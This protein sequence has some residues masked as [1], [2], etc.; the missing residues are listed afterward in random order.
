MTNYNELLQQKEAGTLKPM[1]EFTRDE[2]KK[3]V[4]EQYVTVNDLSELFEVSKGKITDL[5]RIMKIRDSDILEEKQLDQ[6]V[7]ISQN[8]YDLCESIIK[9]YFNEKINEEDLE[10]Y[11]KI[12]KDLK[13]KILEQSETTKSMIAEVIQDK[14]YIPSRRKSHV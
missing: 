13:G 2:L 11:H 5:K 14:F 4:Y 8:A 3:L 10:I 1:S 7:L 6:Y 9:E 12:K